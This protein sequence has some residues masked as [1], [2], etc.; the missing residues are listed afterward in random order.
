MDYNMIPWFEC[1]IDKIWAT[2]ISVGY[3]DIEVMTFDQFI[4]FETSIERTSSF[5]NS[6]QYNVYLRLLEY[7][8]LGHSFRMFLVDGQYIMDVLDT[9]SIATYYPIQAEYYYL[10][11]K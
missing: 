4:N 10:S 1:H 9:Q 11:M 6:F 5:N 3:L 8:S 7:P 2:G